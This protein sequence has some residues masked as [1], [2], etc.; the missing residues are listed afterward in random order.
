[1]IVNREADRREGPSIDESQA[2]GLA[3]L[4]SM[5]EMRVIILGVMCQVEVGWIS[6]RSKIHRCRWQSIVLG[7]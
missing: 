1:M 7:H 6:H 4:Y 3:A 2:I 5:L